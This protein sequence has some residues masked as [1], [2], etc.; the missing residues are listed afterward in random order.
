MPKT[1]DQTTPKRYPHVKFVG[2]PYDRKKKAEIDS[3][4]QKLL[5]KIMQI[6]KRR[7]K[8]V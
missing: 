7:N 5:G 6:M 3:Q 1:V 4:N 2:T 8:S